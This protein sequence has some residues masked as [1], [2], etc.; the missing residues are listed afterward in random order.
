M[1]L[2]DFYW[3]M[4]TGSHSLGLAKPQSSCFDLEG[5]KPKPPVVFISNSWPIGIQTLHFPV[6]FFPTHV[7]P[8]NQTKKIFLSYSYPC[9]EF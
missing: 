3:K 9:V 6:G 2:R 5:E 8:V 1:D 7:Q 4:A